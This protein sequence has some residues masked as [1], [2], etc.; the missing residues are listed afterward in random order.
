MDL[1]PKRRKT[2]LQIEYKNQRDLD[3]YAPFREQKIAHAAYLR[4]IQKEQ[5]ISVYNEKYP[6]EDLPHYFDNQVDG[7]CFTLKRYAEVGM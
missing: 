4:R 6:R 2:K 7:P 3:S 5:N 1:M